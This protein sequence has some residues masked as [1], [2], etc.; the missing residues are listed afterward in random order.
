M[1][2]NASRRLRNLSY[3]C[4]ME[5][6]PPIETFALKGREATRCTRTSCRARIEAHNRDA[7]RWTLV[8]RLANNGDVAGGLPPRPSKPPRSPTE[9]DDENETLNRSETLGEAFLPLLRGAKF[10]SCQSSRGAKLHPYRSDSPF[11]PAS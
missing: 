8:H 11:V 4:R 2:Y 5:Y 3:C 7:L 1:R 6:A 9:D 10:A